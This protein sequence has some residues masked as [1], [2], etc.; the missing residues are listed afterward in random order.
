MRD[1]RGERLQLLELD[2]VLAL[3]LG[4]HGLVRARDGVGRPAR[5]VGELTHPGRRHA[6]LGRE[7]LCAD[8]GV[9]HPELREDALQVLRLQRRHERRHE[10]VRPRKGRC[11]GV[12]LRCHGTRYVRHARGWHAYGGT[13]LRG[14]PGTGC[15]APPAHVQHAGGWCA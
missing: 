2:R 12:H 10:G 4:L 1:V 5:G 3:A 7:A 8:R 6:E 11:L 9:R 13:L 14:G 15:P